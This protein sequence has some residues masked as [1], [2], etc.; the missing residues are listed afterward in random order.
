MPPLSLLFF[1]IQ[2]AGK[3][4]QVEK[5]KEFLGQHSDRP[6]IHIDVGAELRELRDTGSYTGKLTGAVLD[7]GR[8]MPDFM[9]IYL[10]TRR[11]VHSLTGEEHIL[12]DGIA[13]GNDQTR[14]FDDAMIFY[15]RTD[16]QIISIE[17]S[18]AS[19]LERLRLRHRNDD[20]EEG[21]RNRLA[22]Y[23]TDVLPQLELLRERGRTVHSIDGESDVETVH[24]S[25]LQALKLV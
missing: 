5:L 15:G 7:T 17:L 16:Y 19:V 6:I 1:G 21:I 8:R 13:R 3:G 18:E 4:T 11:L 25:V 10:L 23:K 9:P 20:T 12:A 14:A 22:W 2:G 24:Q